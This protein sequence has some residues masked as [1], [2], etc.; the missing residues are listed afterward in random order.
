MK[1]YDFQNE[2][3]KATEKYNRCAYF[4]TMGTGKTFTGGEKLVRLGA[5]KNLVVCQK[6]KIEDWCDHFRE[7]YPTYRVLDLTKKEDFIIFVNSKLFSG[8]YVQIG[9][10]NYDL[11]FRRAELLNLT[12]FTLMLDESQSIKNEKSKRS[13]FVLKMKPKNVILLSGTPV[14][15]KYEELWSQCKLLGWNITKNEFWSRYV[16]WVLF[17][18]APHVSIPQV[19]GYRNIDDLKFNLK[20][21]GAHFLKAE[22]VLTLPEQMFSE[23]NV[24]TTKE[25]R[26]FIKD[27]YVV[28]DDVEYVGD[29]ALKK[30]LYCRMLAS[31]GKIN[32]FKDWIE[33][34]N[35]RL[36]VFYSFKCEL[37]ALK[38]AIGKDRPI[39]VVNGDVRDLK[40][41]E[42]E[43]N[44]IT[45]VQY[46]AGAKGLNL[47]KAN[48]MALFSPT[49]SCDDYMQCLKRIHRL[50]QKK[51]CFYTSFISGID[52][53]IYD[54]LKKGED[55][56]LKLFEVDYESM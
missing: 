42:N 13:K 7:N 35:D 52:A 19:T 49:L 56:T 1:L 44:S 43:S 25:Y 53:K 4:H 24:P 20:L 31:Q 29:T 17:E 11:L 39:S 6:S 30:L 15:G 26:K 23:I 32:A 48:H 10:I 41:Y 21:H 50:G 28:V 2:A 27:N 47:Q 40:A 46:Q 37:K 54:K 55:Y 9:V 18:V 14:G 38:E 12:D 51:T 16:N 5:Y 3:L 22:D 34:C 45:L 33:S 36:V 8:N